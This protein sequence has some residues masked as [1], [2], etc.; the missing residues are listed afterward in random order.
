M[1]TSREAGD[2]VGMLVSNAVARLPGAWDALVDRFAELIWAVARGQ[3]LSPADSADVSQT[4]WLRLAEHLDRIREPERLGGWL[5]VTARNES[6]RTLKRAQRQV[7]TPWDTT[8]VRAAGSDEPE[9]DQ[10]ILAD[11][12]NAALWRAFDTLS[13][14][15]KLL[16][17]CLIAEPSPSYAEVSEVLDIPVG[18]IGPRRNRCLENLRRD[19]GVCGHREVVTS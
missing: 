18:T 6:L 8:T 9:L 13:G 11:E 4:T 10:S 17:R 1:A 14:P 3:G 15:C 5:A 19:P 2:D 12:R 7:P 16:L